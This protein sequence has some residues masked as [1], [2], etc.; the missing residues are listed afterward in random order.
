VNEWITY[1][2]PILDIYIMKAADEA[3]AACS[4]VM[5]L[6]LINNKETKARES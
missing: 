1:N 4:Q 2:A 3:A 6:L 5:A